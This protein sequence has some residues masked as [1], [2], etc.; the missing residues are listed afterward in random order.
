MGEERRRFL[1][2]RA[3]AF[4][5]NTY[6][7]LFARLIKDNETRMPTLSARGCISRCIIAAVRLARRCRIAVQDNQGLY[8]TGG[9]MSWA[10]SAIAAVLYDVCDAITSD[11]CLENGDWSR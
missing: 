5:A 1:L 6:R 11:G 2:F 7:L 9:V 4:R 3:V 10:L 8:L